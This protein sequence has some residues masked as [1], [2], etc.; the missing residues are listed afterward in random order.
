[1]WSFDSKKDY[2]RG[3]LALVFYY[4]N[5]IIW[6]EAFSKYFK[7]KDLSN[8][9]LYFFAKHIVHDH[10]LI[11]LVKGLNEVCK[12]LDR[13]EALLCVLAGD[14]EDAKYKKLITVSTPLPWLNKSLIGS[15][16]GQQ[17]P[18]PRGWEESWV[19]RVARPVQARQAGH[20]PQG[21]RLL[22]RRHQRLR[23]GD[24]GS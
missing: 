17:H 8:A 18:S 19:G 3:F 14:C 24:W 21:P 15:L 16:Q 9:A 11:G 1:M 5:P 6:V 12:A 13:K 4:H 7:G 22:I 2:I 23:W 10:G 20:R